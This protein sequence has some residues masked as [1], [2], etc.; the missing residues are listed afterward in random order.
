MAAATT[1]LAFTA[2]TGTAGL[3]LALARGMHS[4]RAIGLTWPWT[5][6]RSVICTVARAA[7]RGFASVLARALTASVQDGPSAPVASPLQP[8][9]TASCDEQFSGKDAKSRGDTEVREVYSSTHGI[10][11][12]S[13]VLPACVGVLHACK[14]LCPSYL[15]WPFAENCG[16]LQASGHESGPGHICA[17]I[18]Q[19]QLMCT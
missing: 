15:M 13:V 12:P 6:G 9:S 10:G 14:Q 18:T 2:A 16:V 3:L 7:P 5:H 19:I 17:G 8:A 4:C 1:G 11:K